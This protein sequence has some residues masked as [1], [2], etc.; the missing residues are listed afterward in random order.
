MADTVVSSQRKD[1]SIRKSNK[2]LMEKKRRARINNCLGQLKTLT[3]QALKKDSSQ[4]SK[5]EKADILELTVKHLRN[6]QRQQISGSM[7]TDTSVMG[8][9]RAGFNEC[10]NEVMRYLSSSHDINGDVRSQLINHLANCLQAV[11]SVQTPDAIHQRCLQP[12]SVQIPSS[13][14]AS[15]NTPPSMSAAAASHPQ[16]P[17]ASTQ[18]I[19]SP[20]STPSSSPVQQLSGA[21]HIMPGN[22]CNGSAVAVYLGNQNSHSVPVYSLHVPQTDSGVTTFV[23]S[24]TGSSQSLNSPTQLF[25]SERKHS[26]SR[27]TPY[28]TS[29]VCSPSPSKLKEECVWR[30]W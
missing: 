4:F 17:V 19:P 29:P 5:L 25:Y 13:G 28:S 2:P 8:K 6:L 24:P 27:F 15:H 1:P 16:T 14:Q 11:N 26:D 10:A 7:A 18:I 12:I 30:P 9:Y 22:M 21:F 20:T 23:P 3:L